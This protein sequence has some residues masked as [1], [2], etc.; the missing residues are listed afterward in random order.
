MSIPTAPSGV[1]TIDKPPPPR[2]WIPLS[3][4]LFVAVIT[5]LF[6][7]SAL[8]VGVPAY[9]Q[10]RALREIERWGG[11]AKA[12]PVGPWWLRSRISD[13]WL[14]CVDKV[15]RVNL[16]ETV[17]DDSGL[18]RLGALKDLEQLNLS[19]TNVT[20][21]GLR[22]LS[23]LARLEQVCLNE[24]RVTDVGLDHLAGLERLKILALA[25]TTITDAGLVGL[26]R[27]PKLRIVLADGTQVTDAGAAEFSRAAR[28]VHV[29]RHR[30]P[31]RSAALTEAMRG[32]KPSGTNI[33]KSGH[34][35]R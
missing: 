4:R 18:A 33:A 26:A 30:A 24:T 9:Q 2:R 5:F 28:S 3:L 15:Y 14:V 25:D 1:P 21:A 22:H 35:D 13:R 20:D 31:A 17:I 8:W 12:R 19:G 7:G 27:L 29:I 10:D 11:S 34:G 23:G 6:V 16:S 32:R